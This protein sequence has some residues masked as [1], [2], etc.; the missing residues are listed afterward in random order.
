MAQTGPQSALLSTYLHS[1]TAA[2]AVSPAQPMKEQMKNS[3]SNSNPV[4]VIFSLLAYIRNM[5]APPQDVPALHAISMLKRCAV[6][7]E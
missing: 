4:Y 5:R 6:P 2:Q 3:H 7:V 1:L